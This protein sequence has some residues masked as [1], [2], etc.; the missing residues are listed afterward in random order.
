VFVTVWIQILLFAAVA[1][2]VVERG[3]AFWGPRNVD[4]VLFGR[5]LSAPLE[6][7]DLAS[8]YGLT[9]AA[10]N[11]LAVRPARCLLASALRGGGPQLAAESVDVPGPSEDDP[12]EAWFELRAALERGLGAL[13]VAA[14]VSSA[15]AL[16]GVATELHWVHRGDHGLMWMQAG[17]VERTGVSGALLSV[18]LG[19]GASS[20][21]LWSRSALAARA[22]S[23]SREARA[24][25]DAVE[26]AIAAGRGPTVSRPGLP[27]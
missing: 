20:F 8:A 2:V 26:V 7:G 16:V 1:C 24:L 15:L 13:R 14:R 5:A 25:S 19:V 11:A 4:G 9:R 21:A 22:R 10:G 6:R 3:I 27:R 23:I 18:A 12:D 17:L